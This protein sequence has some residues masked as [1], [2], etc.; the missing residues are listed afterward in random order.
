MSRTI[1]VKVVDKNGYGLPGYLVKAYGGS[2]VK[3]DRDGEAVVE[4]TSSQVSI[5]VNGNT[6]Y[7]GSTSGCKS[8]LIVRR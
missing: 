3:T 1:T 2:P 4:A 8:P 6:E 5:Y 7:S